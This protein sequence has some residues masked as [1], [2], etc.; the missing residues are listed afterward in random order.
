MET[1]WC[2]GWIVRRVRVEC[3][4]ILV[5]TDDEASTIGFVVGVVWC[6]FMG[7]RLGGG[8]EFSE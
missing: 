6:G 8:C 5:E 7:I 2:M 1:N 4:I 3:W